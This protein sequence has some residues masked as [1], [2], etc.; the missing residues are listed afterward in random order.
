MALINEEMLGW[1]VKEDCVLW[2]GMALCTIGNSTR[3]KNV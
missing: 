3:G 1:W 2:G